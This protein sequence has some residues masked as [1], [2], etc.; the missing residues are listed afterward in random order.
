MTHCTGVFSTTLTRFLFD[1]ATMQLIKN[2]KTIIF[3]KG[4][5]ES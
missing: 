1:T 5:K 3:Y 4:V 2:T